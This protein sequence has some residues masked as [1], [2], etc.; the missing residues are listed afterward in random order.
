MIELREAFAADRD[1][2]LGLRRRAFPHDD[3][4]KQEPA[5]WEWQFAGGRMFVATDGARVVG[6]FG[7]VPQ[8]YRIGER[9]VPALLA[10][11]AMIDPEYQRQG[12]F[13]RLATF[14]ID[15]V[16]GRVPLVLAFQIRKA[17]L[18]GMLRAGLVEVAS[19]PVVLRATWMGV[20]W[21]AAKRTGRIACPTHDARRF[22][23][24]WRYTT[25]RNGDAFLVSRD[26]VLKG[27]RT[28]ALV[29]FGGE[30]GA[31]RA[32]V[33]DALRDARQRGIPL[34]AALVTRD[35]PHFPTLARCGF[36]RGPHRFRVLAQSFDPSLDVRQRWALTWAATDHV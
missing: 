6:H 28:H 9:D 27:I 16:R 15:S 11:D 30:P 4:E 17:V 13:T 14:A 24:G 5:F 23:G 8:Q 34:A 25:R 18:P 21:I 29:D 12:V 10:V 7:F 22:S 3:L 31:L 2:I 20:P 32:L 33:R 35:H 26:S 19:A 36:V 1:A